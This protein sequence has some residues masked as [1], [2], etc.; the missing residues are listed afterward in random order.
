MAGVTRQQRIQRI[1]EL[2]RE[3]NKMPPEKHETVRLPG[4]ADEP[5]V[6][7]VITIGAEEVLLNHRSHRGSHQRGGS[8]DRRTP[9]SSF[10]NG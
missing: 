3:L 9:C 10:A 7:D 1:D 5:M 6:C 8:A 2:L 4:P